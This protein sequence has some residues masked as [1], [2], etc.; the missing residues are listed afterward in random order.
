ML[1]AFLLVIGLL[2]LGAAGSDEVTA[3]LGLSNCYRNAPFAI[4]TI[5]PS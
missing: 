2:I 5:T 1:W 4:E 3:E